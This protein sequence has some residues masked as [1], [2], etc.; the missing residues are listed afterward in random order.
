[1]RTAIREQVTWEKRL[2]SMSQDV[3]VAEYQGKKHNF[4]ILKMLLYIQDVYS[5]SKD[6]EIADIFSSKIDFK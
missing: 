5:V 3:S 6:K 1:M 2:Q 4:K